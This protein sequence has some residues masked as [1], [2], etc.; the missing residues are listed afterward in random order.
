MSREFYQAVANM[1]EDN[2]RK[3]AA[4]TDGKKRH[5]TCRICT[6]QIYVYLYEDGVHIQTQTVDIPDKWF[7]NWPSDKTVRA[8]VRRCANIGSVRITILDV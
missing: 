7:E 4:N 6:D 1:H 3:F 2:A 5:V 8:R